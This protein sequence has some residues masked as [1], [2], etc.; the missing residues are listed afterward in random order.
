MV[1][2]REV[3]HHP[4]SGAPVHA[5]F[6]EVALDRK[7]EVRVAL[8]FEGKAAGVTL[9]GILQPIVR[10]MAVLCLPTAIPR[11][12]MATDAF[13]RPWSARARAAAR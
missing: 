13:R 2:V 4:V 11:S 9:G 7:I 3:Q 12:A 5:D 8:H 1:L 10:E 6:Y